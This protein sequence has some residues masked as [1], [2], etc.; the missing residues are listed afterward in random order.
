MNRR[1]ACFALGAALLA[2][3]GL[4]GCGSSALPRRVVP[5]D[6]T[7]GAVVVSARSTDFAF[8]PPVLRVPVGQLVRLELTNDGKLDHDVMLHDMPVSGMRFPPGQH[9]HGDYV[10]AHASS[11]KLAWV[12][13][14]PGAIGTYEVTCSVLGHREAGMTAT[15]I[16]E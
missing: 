13:F 4:A 9:M 12:E 14:V 5:L 15:L 2:P 10:A 16:V 11:G 8:H 1:A 3:V 6:P 7:P